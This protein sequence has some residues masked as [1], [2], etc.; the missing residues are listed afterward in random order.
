MVITMEAHACDDQYEHTLPGVMYIVHNIPGPGIDAK[1]F[2]SE[3]IAGCKCI[4]DCWNCPCTRASRNYVDD[5]IIE[6]KLAGPIVECNSFCSCGEDC[7][8][9]VVQKGPLDSLTVIEAGEKGLALVTEKL[10]RKGQFICEYAGEVI[11]IIEARRRIENNKREN[12]MNYV[13]VVSEHIADRAI[14]TCIDPKYFGNI[15]RYCNHSCEPSAALVPVRVESP[16]PRLCLFATRD[17]EPGDEVT[18]NYAAG[19][20]NDS[21]RN[22]SDTVCLC[23]STN[24]A[25]Y[26][27]H[28]PI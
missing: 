26:L 25:G 11:G 21:V 20:D 3:Y 4:S 10:I 27:P 23:G 6:S 19:I 16:M 5:R 14:V 17:I 8:N 24:C 13:L 7:G 2:E 1:E 22:Y 28:D 12:G 18:F 9:R 15:G